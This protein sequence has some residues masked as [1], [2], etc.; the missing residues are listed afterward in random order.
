M[1]VIFF[2]L[3]SAYFDIDGEVKKINC[4][5]LNNDNNSM[6]LDNILDEE[7]PNFE[8]TSCRIK[9][10]INCNNYLIAQI[11]EKHQILKGFCKMLTEYYFKLKKLLCSVVN[12]CHENF[13][14]INSLTELKNFK[15]NSLINCIENISEWTTSDSKIYLN[16]SILNP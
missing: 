6:S 5:M 12:L 4:P 7:D 10:I 15:E 16:L 11:I 13:S 1:K 3:N 14:K 8:G 2:E 9:E